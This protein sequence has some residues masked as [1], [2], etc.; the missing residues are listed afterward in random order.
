MHLW[1]TR[2]GSATDGASFDN[3][4][5]DGIVLYLRFIHTQYGFYQKYAISKYKN[6]YFLK[7]RQ[8]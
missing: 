5:I 8:I 7:Q 6:D 3:D 2:S 4:K 1:L